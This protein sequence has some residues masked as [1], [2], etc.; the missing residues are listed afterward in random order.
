VTARVAL[1]TGASSGIGRAAALALSA[2]GFRVVAQGRSSARLAAL[3]AETPA[4]TVATGLE[5]EA[6]CVALAAR[7]RSA[8]PIQ[9]L[10][11]SA[12][13]GG[14]LDKPI[15]DMT[16]ADWRA[17]MDVNLD[18]AFWL[19][20]EAA[21]D[22]REAGWGR[23][24]LVSSTAGE[25]GAP[26][27]S[28]YCASKHGLIGLMRSVAQDVAPFGGTCNAVNPTWVRT[29]MTDEESAT[30]AAKRGIS[31]DEIWRRRAAKNPAGRIPE[32]AEIASVIAFLCADAAS[33]VNG[34]PMS[35]TIGSLW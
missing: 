2:G 5:T 24:V 34:E 29:A 17:T 10:V 30:E 19:C 9:V 23:I 35:V 12:G 11:H 28:A 27:M 20:R 21:R 13:R 18:A 15:F 22:I 25:V 7:A 8:G 16:T 4:E 32:A 14:H 33:A 6:Q 31:V 1:V 26:A 3:A